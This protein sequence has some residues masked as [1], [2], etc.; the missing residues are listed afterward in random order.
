MEKIF[1]S[2]LPTIVLL[3]VVWAI[4]AIAII[5]IRYQVKK[6]KSVKDINQDER[7]KLYKEID[8]LAIYVSNLPRTQDIINEFHNDDKDM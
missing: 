8:E 4:L 2:A 7:N 3:S 6:E 5:L 1:N